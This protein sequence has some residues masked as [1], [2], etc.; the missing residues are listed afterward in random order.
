MEKVMKKNL[1]LF[2]LLISSR[3]LQSITIIGHRGAAGCAPENTLSSF[4]VAIAAG[5]DIIEFDVWKC[6]SDELMVFHDA[7]LDRITN[8]TGRLQAKTLHELKKLRVLEY[9]TIPTLIEVLD[10]VDRRV[11]VYIELKDEYSAHDVVQLIEY[12]IQNKGWEYADFIVA[13][14][15]HWQLREVKHINKNISVAALFYGIPITLAAS[16][17]EISA[18]ITCVDAEFITQR[19]VD[20]IHNRSML[21]YVFTVNDADTL[22]HILHYGID[23][24]ITDYPHYICTFFSS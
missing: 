5:V 21:A 13:S 23:G 14:F 3:W 2:V 7:I 24:I 10:F 4:A 18:S 12:Y 22:I 17:S 1:L 8:G 11:K 15:D 9:E 16:A 20:D 19:F 6:A